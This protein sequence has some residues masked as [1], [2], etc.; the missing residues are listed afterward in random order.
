MKLISKLKNK[1]LVQSPKFRKVQRIRN[2]RPS[3]TQSFEVFGRS[4]W[5]CGQCEKVG[6]KNIGWIQSGKSVW[7]VRERIHRGKISRRS[8]FRKVIENPEL[9]RNL[10]RKHQRAPM[11]GESW[12]DVC[13]NLS[14]RSVEGR[15]LLRQLEA[16]RE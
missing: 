12:G 3:S 7:R 6:C 4:E 16:F 13:V 15:L 14:S 5:N 9:C 8:E 10:T 11:G 2:P 1:R